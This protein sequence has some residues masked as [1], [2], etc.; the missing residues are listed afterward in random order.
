M[1]ASDES[2]V[3]A[4][5]TRDMHIEIDQLSV[6]GHVVFAGR[7]GLVKVQTGGNVAQHTSQTIHIGGVETTPQEYETMLREIRR[8][9]SAIKQTQL[10]PEAREAAQHDLK[11]VE[12]Q[13]TTP[14]KP[15][16]HILLRAAKSLL[17]YSPALTA[18]ALTLFDQPLVGAIVASAG[19][20]ASNFHDMV[21]RHN[22][23]KDS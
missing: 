9:E 11:T 2:L 16:Q 12:A 13:L 1:S 21:S 14:K 15:N 3:T 4:P 20:A 8:V 18:A 17:R 22:K 23:P 7:D 10:L 19:E 5:Y 6:T